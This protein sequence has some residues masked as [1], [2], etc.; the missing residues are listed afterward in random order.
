MSIDDLKSKITNK[1]SEKNKVEAEAVTKKTA[2]ESEINSKFDP[3]VSDLQGK[4]SKAE[5]EVEVTATRLAEIKAKL[6]EDKLNAKTLAKEAKIAV[7]EKDIELKN[8]LKSIEA[9]KKDKIK[10]I[11]GIIKDLNNQIKTIEKEQMA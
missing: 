10:A 7:K 1:E 3:K 6:S 9:E 5:K 2:A 11:D 4:L 8:R